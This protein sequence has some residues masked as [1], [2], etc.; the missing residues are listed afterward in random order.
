M[1]QP[2]LHGKAASGK[3]Y[4]SFS[5]RIGCSKGPGQSEGPCLPNV[6]W[7]P[8]GPGRPESP[9]RSRRSETP[10]LAGTKTS[11]KFHTRLFPKVLLFYWSMAIRR[12]RATG[13]PWSLPQERTPSFIKTSLKL[14]SLDQKIYGNPKVQGDRKALV[15]P[16]GAKPPPLQTSL[17][18]WSLN[19]KVDGNPKV[20]GN[21]KVQGDRKALVA[22]AGANPPPYKNLTQTLH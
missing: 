16:A 21:P 15:A 20:H 7:Q 6:P 1:K 18:L 17:K 13:K 3:L 22:S 10:S 5:A 12:S 8:E 14:W 4:S 11:P 2:S 9:G 19:Q